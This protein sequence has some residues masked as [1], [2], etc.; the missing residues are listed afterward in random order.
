ML[1]LTDTDFKSAITN[2]F[3]ELKETIYRELKKIV[4]A[5]S[6]QIEN[7]NKNIKMVLKTQT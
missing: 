6:H 4:M 2:P 5:M 7:I 3:T 1:G